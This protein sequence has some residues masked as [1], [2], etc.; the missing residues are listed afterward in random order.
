MKKVASILLASSIVSM[1]L[2]LAPVNFASASQPAGYSIIINS[3]ATGQ[4]TQKWFDCATGQT[5]CNITKVE[6]A[7][8]LAID[9]LNASVSKVAITNFPRN[10]KPLADYY[11]VLVTQLYTYWH[12]LATA[13]SEADTLGTLGTIYFISV[14]LVSLSKSFTSLSKSQPILLSDWMQGP[15]TAIVTM[16]NFGNYLI[17][18]PSK[19]NAAALID[20][21]TSDLAKLLLGVPSGPS[22]RLNSL[23]TQY[24]TNQRDVNEA[25][26]KYLY[27]KGPAPTKS[28]ITK[29]TDII[30]S[31]DKQIKTMESAWF[32]KR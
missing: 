30:A 12:G 20:S 16:N 27:K 14:E 3:A 32:A 13:P 19:M 7:T 31:V 10:L 6:K 22:P 18:S 24:A 25:L 4:A 2:N 9:G 28:W 11:A 17:S 1:V 21:Y 8:S 26:S 5:N 15:L 29:R 23:I